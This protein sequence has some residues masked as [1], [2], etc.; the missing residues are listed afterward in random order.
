[1][2]PIATGANPMA[3]PEEVHTTILGVW[4]AEVMNDSPMF[5]PCEVC[6]TMI[7]PDS[8]LCKKV[9]DGGSCPTKA[10]SQSA[11]LTNVRLADF[12]ALARTLSSTERRCVALPALR[13]CKTCA[14]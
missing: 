4:L 5:T 8:G 13:A 6:R 9:R 2:N 3:L 10:A 14:T 7:D 12:L 1:M 11:V